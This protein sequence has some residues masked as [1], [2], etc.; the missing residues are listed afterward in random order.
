MP[1]VVV[2]GLLL[3]FR[4]TLENPWSSQKEVRRGSV[5]VDQT[6]PEAALGK[7]AEN[8]EIK[9]KSFTVWNEFIS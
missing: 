7:L 1:P 4:S 5:H 8:L 3:A 9:I 6:H 2:F